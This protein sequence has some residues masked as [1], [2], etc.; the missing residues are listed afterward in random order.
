[1]GKILAIII[2]DLRVFLADRSNLPGLLLTPV[3]MTV[4]IGL[5]NGGAFGGDSSIMRLDVIDRTPSDASRQLL[6]AINAADPTLI[7]CPMENT[8][9]DECR[10]GDDAT[11]TVGRGL[12]RV[13]EG[14]SIGLLEIP[15]DLTGAIQQRGSTSLVLHTV[16]DF[17]AGLA[18]QRALESALVRINAAAKAADIGL[19]ALGDLAAGQIPAET[20]PEVASSL[21]Q[22]ALNAWERSPVQ[23]SIELSGSPEGRS[24]GGSLQQ[25]LGQSVPGMGSMFVMMTVFGGMAALIEERRGW[26]LQRLAAMPVRRAALIGGKVLARFSLG[27]LQFLVI[28]AVAAL[29]GMNFGRDPFALVVVALSYTLATTALSFA[30]G[31]QLANPSQAAGLSLLLTLVL[32]PLGGAWWPLEVSPGFM[33]MIGKISPVYWSMTAF[34]QLTY[35]RATLADIWPSVLVLLGIAAMAFQIAIPRFRYQVAAGE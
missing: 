33:Q 29:L 8:V 25:G 18:A 14:T 9:E 35:E 17:G 22:R 3:A 20:R 28:F 21:Y 2:H 24:L 34:T 10:M 16:I 19:L 32:A 7:L 13:V 6:S 11:M 12:S 26:T 30:I 31:S 15:P 5:V 1:M 27:L 23:V 4:I